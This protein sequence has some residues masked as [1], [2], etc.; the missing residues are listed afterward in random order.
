MRMHLLRISALALVFAV[1][2]SDEVREQLGVVTSEDL[3]GTYTGVLEGVTVTDLEDLDDPGR[4]VVVDLDLLHEVTIRETGTFTLTI[5]SSLVPPLRAIVLGAGPVAIN[6]E[7][8]RF[9]GLDLSHQDPRFEALEVKQIV[10]VRYE[11]EWIFVLQL[12]H[13]D[14]EE[15][16][17]ELYVYQYVSYPSEVAD[18]MSNEEAIAYVNAILRLASSAQRH[19][20][21]PSP[22]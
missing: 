3:A 13:V 17:D 19:P 4:Q 16:V 11:G 6:A 22:D 9:E 7:F 21:P 20:L 12:V 5:Q 15:P 8:V 10:F 2:C 1:G 18:R 14:V